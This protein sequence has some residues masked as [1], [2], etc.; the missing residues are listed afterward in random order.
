MQNKYI[1]NISVSLPL[2]SD[3]PSRKEWEIGCWKHIAKTEAS[4]WSFI[5]HYERHNIVMRVAVFQKLVSG[6]SYREIGREL[7]VSPQ[8]ISSIVKSIKEKKYRSYIEWSKGK[9]KS[10]K[11]GSLFS[12]SSRS[13]RKRVRTKFGTTYVSY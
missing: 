5:T 3:Y 12:V 6:K 4:L 8:T 9:R 1:K 7:W 10:K 2:V 11:S 13:K